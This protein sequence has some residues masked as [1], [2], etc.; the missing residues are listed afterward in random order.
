M[1][2]QI[3]MTRRMRLEPLA[4]RHGPELESFARLWEV[5]RYT[6]TIPHPYP[7]GGGT[8]Y[9]EAV[10]YDWRHGGDRNWAVIDKAT[11]RVVGTGG[12]DQSLDRRSM[13]VGYMFAPWVWGKGYATEVSRALV[14]HA[15]RMLGADEVTA[16]AS[17]QNRASCH[18]LTRAGL[19][20]I[21]NAWYYAPPRGHV[22][23]AE[24][25]RLTRREWSS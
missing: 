17:V 7:S 10:A 6:A 2:D 24:A 22:V 16:Y 25:Y 15:F 18:V 14:D 4:P 13:E 12:L 1:S 23:T 21:G 11:G 5:A 20:R 9:A 8:A 19:R 3:V